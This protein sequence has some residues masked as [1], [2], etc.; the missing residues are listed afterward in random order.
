[1][2]DSPLSKL[3]A[4]DNAF[5]TL[6][7]L[8]DHIIN[9]VCSPANLSC[10]VRAGNDASAAKI[11][12]TKRVGA[13]LFAFAAVCASVLIEHHFVGWM[14]TF[15]VVAPCAMQIAPLEKHGGADARTVDVGI[16]LDIKKGSR[17]L[18]HKSSSK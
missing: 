13:C 10:T 17:D 4:K 8:S 9:R 7:D 2:P 6:D 5:V 11:A 14:M 18:I 12:R 16:A 15:G 1:M 3:L